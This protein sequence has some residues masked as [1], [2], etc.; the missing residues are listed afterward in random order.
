[1]FLIFDVEDI[2]KLNPTFCAMLGRR[3]LELCG[4][5]QAAKVTK[6]EEATTSTLWDSL[7]MPTTC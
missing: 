2:C 6:E 4:L 7:R 1:M 5:S 3:G